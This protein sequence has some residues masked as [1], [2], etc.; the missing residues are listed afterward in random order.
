MHLTSV[1]SLLLAEWG[2][3][4]QLSRVALN[5]EL[6]DSPRPSW[7]SR[8]KGSMLKARREGNYIGPKSL[9]KA[10]PPQTQGVMEEVKVV[11][12][13]AWVGEDLRF[14]SHR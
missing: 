6:E 4:L 5:P 7:T 12:T 8:L 3:A 13:V 10:A 11:C 9:G 1:S 14:P 2:R